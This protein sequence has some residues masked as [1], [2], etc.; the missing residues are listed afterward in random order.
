[1]RDAGIRALRTF[2]QAFL[3]FIITS[4]VLSAMA[5]QGI[6][7]WAVLKKTL[8]SALAA[9]VAAGIAYVQNWLE[10]DNRLTV[11]PK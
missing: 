8:L 2:V 10:D 3:G 1:M 9:A 11:L 4:G 7:D 5:T 6:V